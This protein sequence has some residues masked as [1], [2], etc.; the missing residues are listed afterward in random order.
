MTRVPTRKEA[1]DA[2]DDVSN[3][4][5]NFEIEELKPAEKK[6]KAKVRKFRKSG[7]EFYYEAGQI[8]RQEFERV[9]KA[10]VA[11]GRPAYVKPFCEQLEKLLELDWKRL[12]DGFRIAG[13]YSAE[14]IKELCGHTFVGLGHVIQLASVRAPELREELQSEMLSERWTGEKLGEEI[15]ERQGIPRRSKGAGPKVKP[16]A[17]AKAALNHVIK[18]SKEFAKSCDKKWFHKDFDLRRKIEA[19]A[20]EK[21]NEDFQQLIARGVEELENVAAKAAKTAKKLRKA[22]QQFTESLQEIAVAEAEAREDQE[23]IEV[24][25]RRP[26]SV[27][28][29]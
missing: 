21:R 2:I 27:P 22:E 29:A 20:V 23:L 15:R 18:S 6:L 4:V 3:L 14:D 17:T 28:A 5:D 24:S 10:R 26:P 9:R 8:V 13:I 1:A 16:F 25:T 11:R 7:I 19:M 12:Y